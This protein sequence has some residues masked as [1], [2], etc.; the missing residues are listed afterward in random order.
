MDEMKW[1]LKGAKEGFVAI[2]EVLQII[3]LP[4]EDEY[5]LPLSTIDVPVLPA[6][7]WIDWFLNHSKGGGGEILCDWQ[8]NAITP[9]GSKC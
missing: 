1:G 6:W 2:D 4:V 7:T 8:I 9:T 3:K 5:F